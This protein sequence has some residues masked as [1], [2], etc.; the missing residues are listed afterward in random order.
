MGDHFCVNNYSKVLYSLGNP[1]HVESRLLRYFGTPKLTLPH[2]IIKH[3]YNIKN[4]RN[5]LCDNDELA[6]FSFIIIDTFSGVL[7][8]PLKKPGY[9]YIYI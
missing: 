1:Q 3:I 2:S 4:K 8:R 5:I 9:I 6:C 7:D